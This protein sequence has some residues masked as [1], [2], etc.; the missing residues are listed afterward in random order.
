MP[1]MCLAEEMTDDLQMK[2]IILSLT[3]SLLLFL[4]LREG[5]GTGERTW[6]LF[7]VKGPSEVTAA[8]GRN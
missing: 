1:G 7:Q 6:C 2:N 3:N 8:E 4:Y 5:R